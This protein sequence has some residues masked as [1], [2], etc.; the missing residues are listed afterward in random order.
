MSA[1]RVVATPESRVHPLPNVIVFGETG[2]GKSSILNMLQGENGAIVS[3]QATGVT[4]SNTSY[5]KTIR[6]T[7]F[8]VLDTIGL[9]EGTAGT[10]AARNAIKGLYSL[11]Q[12]LEDGINLLVCVMRAPR[13]PH[14]VQQ[15]YQMFY[16]VLCNRQVPI[17]IIIT[18]LEEKDDM[19]QW[20]DD[21]KVI[22]EGRKMAF[23]GHACVTATKGK[24]LEDGTYS[25]EAEYEE[26]RKKVERLIYDL[27]HNSSAWRM[28]R[29][30]WFAFAAV[31]M[32][33]LL[34]TMLGIKPKVLSRELYDALRLYGGL[35]DEEAVT[36]AY[37]TQRKHWRSLF[38]HR[39]ARG[40]SR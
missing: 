5:V 34:A 30:T 1:H 21:N 11:I 29:Q 25:Y 22:F 17:V 6:S 14:S 2:V 13:V 38:S 20:W 9:N 28:P 35:S 26:S 12:Q 36:E 18:G 32:R 19:E 4:F 15:N 24:M 7:T 23:N 39:R 33:N 40:P 10:I 8:R 31:R 16:E 37:K 27:A 3:D